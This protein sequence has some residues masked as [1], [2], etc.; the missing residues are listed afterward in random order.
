MSRRFTT[1]ILALTI[2]LAPVAT[3]PIVASAPAVARPMPSPLAGPLTVAPGGVSVLR[4]SDEVVIDGVRHTTMRIATPA[5]EA[6]ANVLTID[7][8]SPHVRTDILTPEHVAATAAVDQMVRDAGAVAGVNGDF[9]NFFEDASHTGIA[10]TGASSGPEMRDGMIVKSAVP[11]AQR[12]GETAPK[13]NNGTEVIGVTRNRT[14]V[15]GRVG[16]MATMTAPEVFTD[17]PGGVVNLDALNAYGLYRNNIEVFTPDWG[18][19]PRDR[20]AC[21]DQSGRTKPCTT[22]VAEVIVQNSTVVSVSDT[23]GEGQ[24]PKHAVAL[25]GREA[26]ADRLRQL[27]PGD[28]VD[29]AWQAAPSA[30]F[31]WAVGGPQIL[32]DGVSMSDR[33]KVDP[34]TSAGVS[35]DGRFMTL[36]TVDGR[37]ADQKGI[38]IAMMAEFQRQVGASDAVLFD[39]G[40][41]TTMAGI[42]PAA[43][44]VTVWNTPVGTTTRKVANGIGVFAK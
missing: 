2:G 8:R 5:G 15:V 21:G 25:V 32:K 9:F 37:K 41:S 39:G 13:G 35:A 3:A 42:R 12:F 26:G 30:E 6:D 36:I 22:N 14:G 31:R 38:S 19:T 20:A 23:L 29:V 28:T 40:G 11:M 27:K 10:P 4:Q 17:V 43:S 44:D 1:T 7:L 34:R 16:L 24:L 18:T 33:D